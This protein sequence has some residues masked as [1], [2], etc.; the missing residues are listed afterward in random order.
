MIM[1][2]IVG[3][4]FDRDIERVVVAVAVLTG[5]FPKYA[6]ILFAAPA[7]VPVAMRRRKFEA[8]GRKNHSVHPDP[9]YL[10]EM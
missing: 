3:L 6:L 4:A 1:P 2:V 10:A 8:P 7:S 9:I 5:T